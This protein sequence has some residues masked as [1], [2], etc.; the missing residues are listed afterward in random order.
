MSPRKP[1]IGRK[2][3]NTVVQFDRRRQVT[4]SEAVQGTSQESVPG[5]S[6]EPV[7]TQ[8][9]VPTQES[10]PT[11]FQYNSKNEYEHAADCG[12]PVIQCLHC[13]AMCWREESN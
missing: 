6:R 3:R 12:L 1:D 5:T 11:G 7:P 2:K 4:P 13:S 10:V 9:F 8:D